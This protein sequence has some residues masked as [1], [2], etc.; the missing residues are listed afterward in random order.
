[1]GPLPRSHSGNRYILVACDYGT[2]YLEAVPLKSVDA[3]HTVEE[4][5]K[6][7]THVGI[8][9]EILSDQGFNFTSQL[10][11][12]LYRLLHVKALQTSP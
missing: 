11:A 5:V 8:L 1:M 10:L 7:F 3:E 6:L 2:R 9:K 12:E 4:L